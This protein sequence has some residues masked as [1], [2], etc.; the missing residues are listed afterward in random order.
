[1]N[2]TFTG[3]GEAGKV[4]ALTSAAVYEVDQVASVRLMHDRPSVANVAFG[5]HRFKFDKILE[6]CSSV[7]GTS[8]SGL[9]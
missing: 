7:S 6:I 8:R 5:T 4:R 2:G 1:M 3:S 9:A